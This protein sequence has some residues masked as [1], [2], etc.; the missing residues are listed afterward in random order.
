MKKY[1][2]IRL[3][4]VTMS[5]CFLACGMLLAQDE[6]A[7]STSQVSETKSEKAGEQK[8][9][10]VLQK[11]VEGTVSG[12]GK[13]YIAVAYQQIEGSEYEIRIA[14]DE[15]TQIVNKKTID[16]IRPQDKVSVTYEEVTTELEGSS[17]TTYKAK[18]IHFVEARKIAPE[19]YSGED[20]SLSG[21][22]TSP[23]EDGGSI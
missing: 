18:A 20:A 4:I 17:E 1:N 13:D 2:L 19:L 11:T 14:V 5:L 21:A 9:T 23:S 22:E 10:E 8:K 16:E 12:L 6:E 7:Q 3:Y 15:N